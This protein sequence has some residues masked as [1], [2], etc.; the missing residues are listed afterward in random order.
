MSETGDS[1]RANKVDR[2][3]VARAAHDGI[4]VAESLGEIVPPCVGLDR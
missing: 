4:H 1:I 2:Q 3:A